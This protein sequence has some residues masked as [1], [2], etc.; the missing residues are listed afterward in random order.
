M[1]SPLKT[2]SQSISDIY[3]FKDDNGK[4]RL[5]TLASTTIAA[6]YNIFIT[7]IFYTG[8]LSM[9]DISITG[10]G[11]VTFI[12]YIANCFSIF[13]PRILGR[14]KKRK[15]ILLLAKVCFYAVYIIAT[16]LMPQLVTDPDGRLTWFIILSFVAYVIYALFNPGLMTWLYRFYPQENERRTRYIAYNQTFSSI[17]SSIMLFV[18]SV[19]TDAVEGSAEQNQLIIGFR[20]FAY[21]INSFPL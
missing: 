11:I 2:L 8:F 15:W 18:S 19:L 5:I 3:S 14:F 6:I 13:S 20:Y 16:T 10:V 21:E 12:P 4:G 7:G 1:F 17:L 9:Y